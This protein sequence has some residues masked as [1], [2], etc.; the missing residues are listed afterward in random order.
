RGLVGRLIADRKI[1]DGRR[2][3]WIFRGEGQAVLQEASIRGRHRCLR[4]IVGFER[5]VAPGIARLGG[6]AG[7]ERNRHGRAGRRKG[8]PLQYRS[9][10]GYFETADSKEELFRERF[11]E[12]RH[13]R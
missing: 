9:K 5:P 1:V 8:L 4:R 12:P 13:R 11:R 7:T 3:L 6:I 10:D 2:Y